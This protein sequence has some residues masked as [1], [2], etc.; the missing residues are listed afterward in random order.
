MDLLFSL[1]LFNSLST[2]PLKSIA[3]MCDE[4]FEKKK[5]VTVQKM[6]LILLILAVVRIGGNKMDAM[7][8]EGEG[9]IDDLVEMYVRVGLEAEDEDWFE[10]GRVAFAKALELRP[11]NFDLWTQMAELDAKHARNIQDSIRS[12]SAFARAIQID[13][14]RARE[15]GIEA[16]A[17]AARLLSR[18]NQIESETEHRE[19]VRLARSIMTSPI[20]SKQDI[21][22]SPPLPA[23]YAPMLNDRHRNQAFAKAI[24][25]VV[26]SATERVCDIGT[27]SGLLGILAAQNGAKEVI[28]FEI[29]PSLARVAKL[30][31]QRNKLNEERFRYILFYFERQNPNITT[32]N[33]QSYDRTLISN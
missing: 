15:L 20:P 32:I 6:R 11:G 21:M 30:N 9:V 25:S 10:S 2:N 22:K 7:L 14:D 16:N 19:I 24:E 18:S 12:L 26:T 28:G 5:K 13:S 31:A 8:K 4:S 33:Q 17:V 1:F 29:E 27:G 23:W 3:M